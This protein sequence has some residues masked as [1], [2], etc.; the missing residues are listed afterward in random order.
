MAS[1]MATC[2]SQN[3]YFSG[4]WMRRQT[5]GFVPERT[6]RNWCTSFGRGVRFDG[7][8]GIGTTLATRSSGSDGP[9]NLLNV[10]VTRA[11]WVTPLRRGLE[12][13]LHDCGAETKPVGSC[14]RRIWRQERVHRCG[15][16]RPV[17]GG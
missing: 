16:D 1:W 11:S 14:A 3:E 15:C 4:T 2:R 10:A 13:A 8:L 9:P 6:T 17:P 12:D 7:F 5:S